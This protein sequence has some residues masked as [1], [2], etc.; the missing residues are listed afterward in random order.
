MLRL[1]VLTA[2]FSALA[3]LAPAQLNPGDYVVPV[4]PGNAVV[5]IT[6]TGTVTTIC[7][8]PWPANAV[9]MAVN[10]TDL[11][12]LGRSLLARIGYVATVTPAG[13]VTTLASYASNIYENM[14]VDVN[15][16][17]V[18]SAGVS[19]TDVVIRVDR[20]GMLTTLNPSP[21][22]GGGKP[23]G[24]AVDINTGGYLFGD[25]PTLYRV[26][27]D[28]SC[29]SITGGVA[30]NNGI[31]ILSDARTLTAIVSQQNSLVSIDLVTGIMTTI[32]GGF[33]GCFPGLAYDRAND[34]W[35]LAGSCA[36]TNYFVYRVARAGG[37]STVTPLTGAGDVEVY[38]SLNIVA[39][40][41]PSPGAALAL[42]FCEPSSAGDLY[43]AA[44]SF[45]TSPGI[46]TPA[47]VVDLTPDALFA[48]S[49]LAPS[50]FVNFAGVLDA[51][52]AAAAKV[53]V[54][55]VPQLKGFRFYVSFVTVRGSSI[56]AIANT[57][58]FT[59]Q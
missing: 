2:V 22:V 56:R 13:V 1:I 43:L 35:I 31:D 32:Q 3:G 46:P 36:N 27:R 53:V 55:G 30:I 34:A 45:S 23:R 37:L 40:A 38:G 14:A 49:Q 39:G 17:Y 7:T 19:G 18:M 9:T 6:P 47:G 4:S 24:I 21:A 12:V 5:Q 52:G 58:G 10:N 41:D 15:G 50:M 26:A 59:I 44:A 57:Q 11:A 42:R 48:L 20:F 51:S 54:P 29:T 16:T 33:N 8:L 28:G 25:I